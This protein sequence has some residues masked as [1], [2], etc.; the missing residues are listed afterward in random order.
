[1]HSSFFSQLPNLF[2]FT[3]PLFQYRSISC[4]VYQ[5]WM[6]H[7]GPQTALLPFSPL[8]CHALL[9]SFSLTQL[10]VQ[11][12]EVI[13]LMKE[14]QQPSQCL[15]TL[16]LLPFTSP[17]PPDLLIRFAHSNITLTLHRP[18][19]HPP[20][21]TPTLLSLTLDSLGAHEF[22]TCLSHVIWKLQKV[23]KPGWCKFGTGTDTWWWK[24]YLC[25]KWHFPVTILAVHFGPVHLMGSTLY[26]DW[27]VLTHI[28]HCPSSTTATLSAN[29]KHIV[30][31]T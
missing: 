4:P 13:N 8:P 27:L 23:E 31:T 26:V 7:S 21:Q 18:G 28:V 30:K 12:L 17:L 10:L 15:F 11:G 3:W 6:T 29:C 24:G 14:H 16:Q 1:M 2:M 5:G 22:F 25:P 20:T 19:P 9:M